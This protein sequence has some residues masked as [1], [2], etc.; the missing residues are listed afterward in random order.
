MLKSLRNAFFS[1]VVLLLPLAATIIVV[2]FLL[3]KIGA[4]ASK[5]FFSFIDASLRDKVWVDILLNILSTLIIVMLI[6]LLGLFSNYFLGRL[7]LRFAER[8]ITSVPFIKVVYNTVKQIVDTFGKENRAVFQEVVLVHYPRKNVYALGFLTNKAKGE[9]QEKTGQVVVNVF[10]PT[11]PNPTS[12]FLLML[13]EEDV[14]HLDMSVADGMKLII[15]GGAVVPNGETKAV[16]VKN[17]TTTTE[18]FI[19]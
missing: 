18:G 5:H 4:P 8:L 2:S 15:S 19:E 14:V 1:G 11:T 10:I 9:V 3:E 12:G 17:P 6:T 16:E 13:P 7:A